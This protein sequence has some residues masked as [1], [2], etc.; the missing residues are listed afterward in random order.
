MSTILE[1][2]RQAGQADFFDLV[3]HRP[4]AGLAAKH[5][6]RA[7]AALGQAIAEGD[8]PVQ[9]WSALLYA[10]GRKSDR[11]RMALKSRGCP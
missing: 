10:E 1:R 5:P 2:A 11:P 6:A 7:L 8:V 4:F 9:F 3:E